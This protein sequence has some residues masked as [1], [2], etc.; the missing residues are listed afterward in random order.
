MQT[1]R[2][3]LHSLFQMLPVLAQFHGVMYPAADHMG[4]KGL[5]YHIDGT[6]IKGQH[7][8]IRRIPAGDH[9]HRK[10]VRQ[11]CLLHVLQYFIAVFYRHDDI[12]QNRCNRI[13]ILLY[14]EKRLFTILSFQNI[15]FFLKDIPKEHPVKLYIIYN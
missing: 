15:I 3:F 14:Q 10:F 12:Q 2:L 4:L 6:Q 5:G 11:L 7:F 8:I 9:D 1:G 13:L